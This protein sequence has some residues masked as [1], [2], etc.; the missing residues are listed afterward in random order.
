MGEVARVLAPGELAPVVLDPRVV[1]VQRALRSSPAHA[2]DRSEAARMA[3]LSDSRFSHLFREQVGTSYQRY[4]L[5]VRARAAIEA[6]VAGE[7]ITRAA[8]DAGFSDH[9]H[10]TR[11][12]RRLVGQPPSYLRG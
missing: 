11:T 2:P 9:A 7:S 1:A 4:R 10:L 6:L 12:M 3:G 5:W 8:L